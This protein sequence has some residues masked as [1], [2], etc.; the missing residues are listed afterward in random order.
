VFPTF[1]GVGDSGRPTPDQLRT[2]VQ[3]TLSQR[4]REDRFD[5]VLEA[6]SE[7]RNPELVAAYADAGLTWW[8]EKLGWFRGLISY[9]TQRIERGPPVLSGE[10]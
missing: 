1:D 3:Y 4:D 8:V 7:D 10:G 6:Q 9:T 5:V 2:A